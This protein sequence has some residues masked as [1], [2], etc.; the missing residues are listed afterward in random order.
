MLLE[1]SPP[2]TA[3]QGML[4]IVGPN[5]RRLRVELRLQ[6]ATLDVAGAVADRVKARLAAFFDTER[7]GANRDGWPLGANPREED[8][9]EALLDVE[10]LKSIVSVRLV[11]AEGGVSTP[12]PDTLGRRDLAMLADDGVRFE[13]LV[14][15]AAE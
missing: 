10:R 2:A 15:E 4:T 9:A 11:E 3:G 5:V 8:V 1:A 14:M 6:V 13:F 12:W 7:G